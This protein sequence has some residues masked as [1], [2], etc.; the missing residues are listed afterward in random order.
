MGPGSRADR[1]QK[2]RTKFSLENVRD[3]QRRRGNNFFNVEY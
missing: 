1:N 3:G 2:S